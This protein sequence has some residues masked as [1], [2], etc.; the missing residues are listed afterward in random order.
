MS[1][2]DTE[3]KNKYKTV[4]GVSKV[5]SKS[6]NDEDSLEFKKYYKPTSYDRLK[7]KLKG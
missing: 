4:I 5:T 3:F 7:L 2:W 1:K 6:L